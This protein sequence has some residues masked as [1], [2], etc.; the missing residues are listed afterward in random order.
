MLTQ[1]QD[2]SVIIKIWVCSNDNLT[3]ML[4]VSNALTGW[5]V[6]WCLLNCFWVAEMALK[7]IWQDRITSSWNFKDQYVDISIS[8]CIKNKN[9]NASEEASL[10][11]QD[12]P[13]PPYIKWPKIPG[14]RNVQRTRNRRTMNYVNNNLY[15]VLIF[16]IILLFVISTITAKHAKFF[17][18]KAC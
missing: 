18:C 4:V 6:C 16:D 2:L 9:K 5:M 15:A 13:Y 3:L 7:L 11:V 1:S 12:G 17:E 14:Q 8:A 10:K